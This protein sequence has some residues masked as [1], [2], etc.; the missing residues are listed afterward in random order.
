[1]REAEAR[2]AHAAPRLA[3][4]TLTYFQATARHPENCNVARW[5]ALYR[6]VEVVAAPG[7][8]F[9]LLRDAPAL[10]DVTLPQLRALDP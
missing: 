8:H 2:Y 10:I 3:A 1:M 4:T 9:S 7:D 5:S 6:Q